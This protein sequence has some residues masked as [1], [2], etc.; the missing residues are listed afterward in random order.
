MITYLEQVQHYR[1]AISDT[2]DS[3]TL[4]GNV[5]VYLRNARV[6]MSY[7]VRESGRRRGK[8]IGNSRNRAAR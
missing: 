3:E 5:I 2:I 1:K 8:K 6:D 4:R 7:S